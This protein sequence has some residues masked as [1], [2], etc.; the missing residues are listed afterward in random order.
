MKIWFH[1]DDFGVTKEQSETILTCYEFGNLNSIS[2]IPN[3]KN[4]EEIANLLREKDPD[5]HIRR[6]LHLN[7]VEGRPISDSDKVPFLVDDKGMFSCSFMKLFLQ[8]FLVHGKKRK[9]L[10]EQIKTE[11]L[12]QWDCVNEHIDQLNGIDAHQHYHMIP[13]VFEALCEAMDER[14]QISFVRVPVDSLK[15]LLKTPGIW[16]EFKIINLVKWCILR[17][18]AGEVKKELDKRR[19]NYP[20]FFGIFFTCKMK[21]NVVKALL[22]KYEEIA[23]EKNKD[24]ELMFHPGALHTRDELL[25]PK[26]K[27]LYD[28]YLSVNREL[29]KE[30]LLSKLQ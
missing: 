19:I 4:M 24:L 21:E 28:F 18:H 12:A 26:S 17:L 22:H 30:C 13:I 25:D 15:P 7:F 14:K 5:C 6:I 27:E 3:T 8:D 23:I 2:V 9:H 20:E 1:A 11:I 16:R 29:E 10:R